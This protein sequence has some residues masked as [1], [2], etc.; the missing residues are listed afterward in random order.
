MS[1]TAE[2]AD[3]LSIPANGRFVHYELPDR[4]AEQNRD[5]NGM[6]PVVCALEKKRK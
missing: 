3:V 1:P 5:W 4:G 6:A 2:T